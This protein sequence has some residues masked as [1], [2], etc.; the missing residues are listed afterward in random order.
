LVLKGLNEWLQVLGLFGVLGGLIFVGLQLSLDR[1]VALVEGPEAALANRQQWAELVGA[2]SDVWVKGLAGE[3]L[4]AAESVTFNALASARQLQYLNGYLRA[5]RRLSDQL[6]GRFVIEFARELHGN[7][8]F[9]KWWEH[10]KD[11]NQE[12]RERTG[13]PAES[14]WGGAVAEELQR[15]KA[16]DVSE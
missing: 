4:T 2:N 14:T 15:L 6:P 8:G 7:P 1:Q 11:L 5:S 16:T 13:L 12:Q 9:I 3:P 10:D